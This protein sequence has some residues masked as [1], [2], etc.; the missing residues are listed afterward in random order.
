[1]RGVSCGAL[2]VLLLLGACGFRPVMSDGRADG[3]VADKLD[4]IEVA[5]ILDR[6]GQ[7]MR[8]YL[9]DRFYQ[10]R[11]P[12]TAEYR[13]DVVLTTDD[14]K[15]T[16]EKDTSAS[17]VQWTVAATFRLVHSASG[18]VVLQG[19]S[20]A[21]PDYNMSYYQ[22]ASF[23]AQEEALDRGLDYI[24]NDIRTRVALYFARDPDQ[25]PALPAAPTKVFTP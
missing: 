18:K 15:L 5:Q 6:S 12:G 14:Q 2:A 23:V 20:R 9:I 8:N 3:D 21:F 25:R 4:S 11:R 17:R 24:S 7:K 16:I 19:S 1:M 22:W 10:H 13:L